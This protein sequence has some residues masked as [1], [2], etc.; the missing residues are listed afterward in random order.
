MSSTPEDMKRRMQMVAE[1]IKR[2]AVEPE[3]TESAKLPPTNTVPPKVITEPSTEE[4]EPTGTPLP[5]S[6]KIP[7]VN[8]PE[9]V[10]PIDFSIE[11]HSVE[12]TPGAYS[13]YVTGEATKIPTVG[14]IMSDFIRSAFGSLFKTSAEEVHGGKGYNT[15]T[16]GLSS[17]KNM[18]TGSG[19]A[20]P[21]AVEM[22]N[23]TAEDQIRR[24]RQIEEEARRRREEENDNAIYL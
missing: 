5:E 8:K 3:K 4:L 17:F 9:V 24:K 16:E 7:E 21:S 14:N 13:G 20:A 2:P 10:P 11:R 1:E 18:F 6:A 12:E 19:A 15:I 22:H 23:E